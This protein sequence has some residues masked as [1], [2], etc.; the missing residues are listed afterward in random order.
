MKSKVASALVILTTFTGCVQVAPPG[1]VTLKEAFFTERD[2]TNNVDS[3]AAWHGPNDEHWLIVT[4]KEGHALLIYDA[5]DGS[6]IKRVGEQGTKLG[7][8]NRPNGVSVIGDK[9]FVV[10][11]DNQRVQ[12]LTLPDFFQLG[13]F[14]MEKL[15]HPYGL[16]ILAENEHEMTVYVTDNYETEMEEKPPVAELNRRVHVYD[17]TTIE[18]DS[19]EAEWIRAFGET[20]GD[21][22]LNIVESIYG[23]PTQGHLMVGDEEISLEGQSIKVYST[24]GRFTGKV[25]GKEQFINQPEGIALWETGVTTGYWFFTDQGK[26]LNLFHV[27]DR[28]TFE[29]LG[30]FQGELTMNT[31][32]VWLDPTPSERFPR[33]AFYAIH[34]D[35]NATAFSLAEVADALKLP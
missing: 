26:R 21:G 22:V 18:A 32:G 24:E 29:Y 3:L 4:A 35:G 2:E 9:V 27:F 17:V 1:T 33:G 5:L 7:Q 10:E 30:T 15:V 12:V 28:T 23:D 20:S 14:G 6:F 34:N 8:F 13:S 16:Y 19:V 11:R 25:I 31:D